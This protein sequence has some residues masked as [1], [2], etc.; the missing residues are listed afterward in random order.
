[1]PAQGPFSEYLSQSAQPKTP[2]PTGFE[3]NGA[4]IAYIGSKF[5]EGLRH[6]R[7]QRAALAEMENE[8]TQKAYEQAIHMLDQAKDVDP[9][10]KSQLYTPLMQAY[11]GHIAGQKESSKD[12]GHPF[13]DMVKNA[14]VNMLGG[15]LP[16]AK[17]PLDMALV[18]Q[19]LTAL[20]D[21]NNKIQNRWLQLS[22]GLRQAVKN[23]SIMTQEAVYGLP[24]YQQWSAYRG[25]NGLEGGDEW[26]KAMPVNDMDVLRKKNEAN[27][28][29]Q[30]VNFGQ[31]QATAPSPTGGMSASEVGALPPE[32]QASQPP[33]SATPPSQAR[34]IHDLFQHQLRL[35]QAAKSIK[36]G[37]INEP[38]MGDKINA[39]WA[40]HP[41]PG[42]V[43]FYSGVQGMPDGYYDEAG[44]Q[45]K[46]PVVTAPY[47]P[48]A[49]TQIA[50]VRP[51]ENAPSVVTRINKATGKSE[52][53][54]GPD[55]QP[56]N[57]Y[58]RTRE[59]VVEVVDPTTG[60]TYS[61]I[62]KG[63]PQ[64]APGQN[65]V[66]A[67]APPPTAQSSASEEVIPNV[68]SARPG[69][70]PTT[71]TIPSSTPPPSVA[72]QATA[73]APRGTLKKLGDMPSPEVMDNDVDHYLSANQGFQDFAKLSK[74]VQDRLKQEMLKRIPGSRIPKDKEIERVK[75]LHSVTEEFL[76]LYEE[77][78]SL[79]SKEKNPQIQFINGLI[80]SNKF[81]NPKLATVVANIN[82]KIAKYGQALGGEVRVTDADAARLMGAG[83]KTGYTVDLNNEQI[84][85][86]KKGIE[87]EVRIGLPG[88][89]DQQLAK[90][91]EGRGG[92]FA[93]IISDGIATR[94][95]QK[96]PKGPGF[97]KKPNPWRQGA[98]AQQ[99]QPAGIQLAH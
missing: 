24:E 81:T 89:P 19:T 31:P 49:S 39:T 52:P 79:V 65:P 40:G 60:N 46:D 14:A 5:L 8:K 99:Q 80:D 48:V 87:R 84:E 70:A 73:T 18:G 41:Q 97:A 64:V 77:L 45:V 9:T 95:S 56:L 53:V 74:P 25:A 32:P 83:P 20:N 1:M 27:I 88:V 28:A 93:Q 7:M 17:A 21:P 57:N 38:K 42:R 76:P 12:T 15:N 71:A 35:A 30:I 55:G 72:S 11:L 2:Q 90:I 51:S 91:A 63:S 16:K 6:G 10:L 33:P 43:T 85:K 86:F 34:N 94:N 75:T 22:N 66:Q 98:S 23:N 59:F 13:T 36:F 58:D 26:I 78:N 4:S 92:R 62:Q 50:N 47:N 29:S 44:N 96:M 61:T 68:P 54:I 69:G 82:A 3:G 67:S 37:G